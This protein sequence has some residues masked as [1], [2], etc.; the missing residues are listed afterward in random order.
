MSDCIF[1]KIVNKIIS[2][3]LIYEDEEIIAFHDVNPKA[4]VHILLIPKV[5]IESMLH[6]NA[7]HTVLI[8]KI[9]VKANAIALDMGIDGYKI[10]I[11][12]G[13]KGGQEVFHLHIHLLANY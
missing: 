5:H 4:D 13:E 11:H 1:C 10:N 2:A 7:S 12:T 6:L 9:L 3:K 8:G